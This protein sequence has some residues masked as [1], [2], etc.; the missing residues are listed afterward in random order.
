M[1][2]EEPLELRLPERAPGARPAGSRAALLA[3]VP[4]RP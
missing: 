2:V 3:T 1:K 4:P